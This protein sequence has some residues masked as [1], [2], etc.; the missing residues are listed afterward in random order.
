MVAE[1][2]AVLTHQMAFR[3][4]LVA[5]AVL[6]HLPVQ[7]VLLIKDHFLGQPLMETPAELQAVT[8]EPV[9]A[10]QMEPEAPTLTRMVA[11]AVLANTS[12]TLILMGQMQA[13]LAEQLEAVVPVKDTLAEAEAEPVEAIQAPVEPQAEQAVVV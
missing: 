8:M 4:A 2:A 9:V 13:I 11:Q 1:V 10:V 7:G 5:A 12:P 3:E 6:T